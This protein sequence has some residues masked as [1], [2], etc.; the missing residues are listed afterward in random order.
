[1]S[2]P[3][4]ILLFRALTYASLFVG[5]VLVVVLRE[6]LAYSGVAVP[7][8]SGIPQLAGLALAAM[9]AGLCLACVAHLRPR[10]SRHAGAV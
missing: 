5:V 9:G 7:A 8:F 3:T 10:R 1:M 2:M 4:V 6:L